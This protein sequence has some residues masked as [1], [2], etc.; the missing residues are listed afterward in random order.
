[1]ALAL[2]V[3]RD[4]LAAA[5]VADGEPV[6][7]EEGQARFAVERF[8]LTANNVTYGVLGDRLRY[9]TF[10]PSGTEGWGRVPS[11]GFA[12][13]VA[14]RCADVAEGARI[15]GY[16]PMGGELVL[17]PRDVGERGLYDGSDHRAELPTAYN[18]Y[19]FAQP[20]DRD[21]VTMVLQPLFVTSVLLARS[22]EGASRV[23]FSSAS[24][25]TALGTAFLLARRGIE[26]AGITA[27]TDF[28]AGLGVY[29]E[30]VGYDA[31]DE[32]EPSVATFVDLAGNAEVRAAVH[33]HFGA[34]LQASVLVGATHVDAAP[35]TPDP[36]PG[37][38]PTL[39]FAPDHVADGID[40][41]ALGELV[42]WSAGWLEIKRRDGPGAVLA[43]WIEAVRGNLPPTRGLSLALH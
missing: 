33:R 12:T 8:G 13:A 5:R 31:I 19:R 34:D 42:E 36:L 18:G 16:V 10:F 15:F 35:P 32:L 1:M 17:T 30:I 28:A 7:L 38:K 23:I 24:S 26:T 3:R 22:L 41:G 39:F 43:A 11:W 29:D 37:P 25:K 6:S 2:E 20:S 21:D 40:T 4:D 14:S 9:W 27:S